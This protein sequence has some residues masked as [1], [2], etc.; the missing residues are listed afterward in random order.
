MPGITGIISNTLKEKNKINLQFMINSMKHE[1]YY[2]H[3]S[4][5][6]EH[7]GVYLGW[8]CHKDSFVDCMP[9]WNET[10]DKCLLFYG[11]NFSDREIIDSLKK[12]GH[13]F[14]S[15]DASYLI[16]LYEQIGDEFFLYLNGFFHGV[17]I[18]VPCNKVVIFNDRFGMQRV[19]YYEK[20]DAFLFSSEA[21][22]LLKIC[23]ELREIDPASLGQL[24]SM[25]CILENNNTL[26]KNIYLLPSASLWRFNN[27]NIEKKEHYFNQKDWENQAPL[28]KDIFYNEL[29]E[30][31]IKI[32][33]RYL[34][35]SRPIGMSLTGGLDTRI[36]IA[37]SQKLPKTL[38]CYTFGSIYR[39]TFDVKVARKVAEICKQKHFT[40]KADKEFL[41]K[42]TFLSDK[43]VYIS[44]GY[45]DAASG[46]AELYMNKKAR[47]IAP[48]RMTGCY[49]SEVL[50]SIRGFRYKP[51]NKYLFNNEFN[52]YINNAS[53]IFK[54]NIKGHRLSCTV[55]KEAPFFNYNRNSIEQSQITKRSP[56]M[57]NELISLVY[58][59]PYAAVTNDQISLQLV[60][61]GNI[62]LSKII[63]NRGA[64]G[65]SFGLLSKSKQKYYEVLHLAEI[66]YDYGMPNWL[67]R[68][69][70]YLTTFHFEKLFLGRNN[71]YHFRIW[72]RNELSDYVKEILLDKRTMNRP[73][74]NKKFIEKIVYSHIERGYNYVNEINTALTIELIHRLLIENI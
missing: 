21:K 14:N 64:G 51:T 25:G 71:F 11:E 34:N 73:Y 1:A 42:F 28:E 68:I 53:E 27:G 54:E 44:D 52:I 7:I 26:Y 69:D 12:S 62:Q 37:Y 58:K 63:T 32:L 5:I 70:Y 57:D 36:I 20:K 47:N 3:G 30:T 23:P 38:P 43:A 67:S 31:F 24:L 6:N 46:S 13:K 56:F 48:I 22:S 15:D 9:I 35:D 61:D 16:H 74:F 65:N 66:G 17:L 41:S 29:K 49:G 55:F 33:P 8:V 39:D 18:D 50:R 19:Y 10:K 60:K 59:A 72:F 4:Y 45:I 40:I 2:N